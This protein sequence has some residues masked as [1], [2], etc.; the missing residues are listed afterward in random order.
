MTAA[1]LAPP[2]AVSRVA[3][4]GAPIELTVPEAFGELRWYAT[5]RFSGPRLARQFFL[6]PARE[7][8]VVPTHVMPGAREQRVPMR[9]A[10]LALAELTEALNRGWGE[11]DSRVAMLLQEE[12]AGIDVR[13]PPERIQEVL[14]SD[15]RG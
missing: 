11:R 13:V 6:A 8:R 1:L 7:H 9:L 2:T 3:P 14:D 5:A 12:R 15:R 4:S 10:E